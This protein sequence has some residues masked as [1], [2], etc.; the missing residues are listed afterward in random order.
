MDDRKALVERQAVLE[1]LLDDF[2]RRVTHIQGIVD[3]GIGLKNTADTWTDQI[4]FQVFVRQKLALAEVPVDQVIPAEFEGIPVDV[5]ELT[6]SGPTSD[7]NEHRPLVGGIQIVTSK[8][9]GIGTLGCLARR[10]TPEQEPVLLSNHHVLSSGGAV[11]GDE[12]GQPNYTESCCCTC[13]DVAEILPG[14]SRGGLVDCAIAKLKSG[15]GWSAQIRTIGNV[16]GVNTAVVGEAVRKVGASSDLTTGTVASITFPTTSDG[17]PFTGQILVNPTSGNFQIGGDSGAALV[18]ATG[19]VIGLMW[20]RNP[21]S[22]GPNG[23]ASPIAAVLSTLS[24]TI[25][26]SGGGTL[27]LTTPGPLPPAEA[28]LQALEAELERSDA[29]RRILAMIRRHRAEVFSLVNQNRAVTV[30]W[31]RNEG[32]A[33]LA[34]L[35]R[36]EDGAAT[37]LPRVVNGVPVMNLLIAM[38]AALQEHGSPDLRRDLDAHALAVMRLVD[39]SSVLGDLYGPSAAA[40]YQPVPDR[41]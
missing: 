38:T 37:P 12:V 10:T 13:G 23:V 2:R 21:G 17:I 29:G 3:V 33:L 5:I 16:A 28:A 34:T 27:A 32:P 18:N 1:R 26:T 25:P 39:Q 15:V 14:G 36:T 6:S 22:T 20:G 11:A 9:G 41:A 35:L 19:E 31:R 4:S 30:A 40:A 24:I 8:D 7:S